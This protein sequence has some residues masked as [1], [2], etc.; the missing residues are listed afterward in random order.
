MDVE[1]LPAPTGL[2]NRSRQNWNLPNM[3]FGV[4]GTSGV[5]T[6]PIPA[7]DPP[8]SAASPAVP[9]LNGSGSPKCMSLSQCVN[10][11]RSAILLSS[12]KSPF[13]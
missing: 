12:T 7:I 10:D 5:A 4:M 6:F 2:D 3:R 11:D 1:A 9:A 13:C 8:H